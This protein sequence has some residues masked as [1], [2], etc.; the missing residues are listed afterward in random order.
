MASFRLQISRS[1]TC[2]LS[3]AVFPIF[4]FPDLAGSRCCH[5]IKTRIGTATSAMTKL[6]KIWKSKDISFKSKVKL[7]KSLVLSILLYGCEC[8]TLTAET[9]KR[10]Q[11]FETKCYRRILGIS[12]AERKTNN[13]V[14][15]Q[16]TVLSGPQEPLLSIIKRRKLV[17]FGHVTRHDSIPKT[18]LQ[19]TV[20]GSRRRGRQTKNWM[21]NVREWTNLDSP[22]LLR[23]AEDRDRWRDFAYDTS[24]LPPLRP[25]RLGD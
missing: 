13:F 24:I 19:G 2:V 22:T 14:L 4:A 5:K 10:I 8:W 9:T 15:E 17:Y 7:Y 12:W 18:V 11:T 20:E 1:L 6:D 25:Q 3:R 16:V 21:Q 23:M